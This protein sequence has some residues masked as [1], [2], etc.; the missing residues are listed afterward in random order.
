MGWKFASEGDF[1]KCIKKIDD[2]QGEE[3]CEES[4]SSASFFEVA[5]G[6]LLDLKCTYSMTLFLIV[7]LLVKLTCKRKTGLLVGLVIVAA[8]F[9]TLSLFA[10]L[11][12]IFLVADTEDQ[13]T[14]EESLVFQIA[15]LSFLGVFL[16]L[17]ICVTR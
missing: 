11:W 6:L 12:Q 17:N 7:L 3:E 10:L 16:I 14:R 4:S 15:P 8:T 1:S 9:E 13:M 5:K 2:C